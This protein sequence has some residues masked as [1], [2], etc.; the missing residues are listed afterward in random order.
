MWN[1]TNQSNTNLYHLPVPGCNFISKRRHERWRSSYLHT[2]YNQVKETDDIA[3]FHEGEFESNFIEA[4]FGR[5]VIIV[6]IYRTRNSSEKVSAERYETILE[7]LN[8]PKKNISIGTDHIFD[9][10]K[11]DT[12]GNTLG[13]L[14]TL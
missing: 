8:S 10:L 2:W 6:V 12:H 3:T 4:V 5:K 14:D 9:Y 13:L 11:V 7:K 1:L